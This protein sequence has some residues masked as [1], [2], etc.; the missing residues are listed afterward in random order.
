MIDQTIT[1]PTQ[2]KTR[3]SSLPS[4]LADPR[5]GCLSVRR[6]PFVCKCAAA[7]PAGR[8]QPPERHRHHRGDQGPGVHERHGVSSLKIIKFFF[9]ILVKLC[10]FSAI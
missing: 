10:Y 7:G 5:R 6:G 9:L 1:I 3:T 2:K 4:H 8:W